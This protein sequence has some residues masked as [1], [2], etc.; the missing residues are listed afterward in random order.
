M[1][2]EN[3][4]TYLAGESQ[5]PWYGQLMRKPQTMAYLCQLNFWLRDNKVKL[6]F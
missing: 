3:V 1:Q 6:E 5:W 2:R 4:E